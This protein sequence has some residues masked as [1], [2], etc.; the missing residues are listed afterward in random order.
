[1][2]SSR[3]TVLAIIALASI[4]F[5]GNARAE[6][7]FDWS[8]NE[9]THVCTFNAG[10]SS[11]SHFV[12]YLFKFGDGTTSSSGT[13]THT[14]SQSSANVT[15]EV[16]SDPLYG[17]LIQQTVTCYITAWNPVGPPFPTSGRCTT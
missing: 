5:A 14:Y 17:D 7:C 8:C 15:L 13:P 4:M 9:D 12:S 10:C 3:W 16:N 2:K 6:A 11:A 1:M